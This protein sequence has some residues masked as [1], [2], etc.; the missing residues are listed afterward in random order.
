MCNKMDFKNFTTP[1]T[2]TLSCETLTFKNWRG[3]DI[4][5]SNAATRL[6][7]SEIFDDH[8]IANLLENWKDFENLPLLYAVMSDK[9]VVAY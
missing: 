2:L 5:Q 4:S 1:Q 3:L 7:L 9:N 8:F 6:R